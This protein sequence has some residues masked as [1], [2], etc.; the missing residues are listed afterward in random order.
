MMTIGAFVG[1]ISILL[2]SFAL[3]YDVGYDQGYH[4]GENNTKK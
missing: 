3:G 1:I 4:H 2:G